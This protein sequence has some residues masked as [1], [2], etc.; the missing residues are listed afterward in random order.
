[1]LQHITPQNKSRN[2][3]EDFAEQFFSERGEEK[4]EKKQQKIPRYSLKK[5]WEHGFDKNLHQD[6]W[7]ES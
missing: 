1:M 6:L 3:Q 2:S 7:A 4:L 5:H